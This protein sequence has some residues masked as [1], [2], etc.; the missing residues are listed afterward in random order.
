MRLATTP[1]ST[2]RVAAKLAEIFWPAETHRNSASEARFRRGGVAVIQISDRSCRLIRAMSKRGRP[3]LARAWQRAAVLRRARAGQNQC[4]I[5]RAVFGERGFRKRVARILARACREAE[6]EAHGALPPREQ[7][8]LL[9]AAL[10]E[11][12]SLRQ[13]GRSDPRWRAASRWL[14]ALAN[15]RVDRARAEAWRAQCLAE[16]VAVPPPR[17]RLPRFAEEPELLELDWPR[18]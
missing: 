4:E 11:E 13:L 14:R 16:S 7:E 5:A 18:R 8:E 6:L 17:P 9:R 2:P 1:R 12:R 15:G 3:P 10:A